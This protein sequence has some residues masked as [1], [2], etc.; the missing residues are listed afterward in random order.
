METDKD[1]RKLAELIANCA[2]TEAIFGMRNVSGIAM[3]AL[4]DGVLGP[5]NGPKTPSLW[6][7]YNYIFIWRRAV[8]KKVGRIAGA[9]MAAMIVVGLSPVTAKA[10]NP[11]VQTI[12]TT[13]P[14]P[15]VYGDTLYVYTGH[16]EDGASYYDMRDWHCYS[17]KDM[18]NWQDHGVVCSLNTFSWAKSDAWAGQVIERNGKFYYYV[19]VIAKQGGNSIGVAVS[20]S[21]TGPFKDAIGRPLCQGAS[22]ID[23]TV[24]VDPDG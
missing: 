17:T 22:F 8:M 4:G 16:D 24:Y 18:V 20:D 9:L 2:K 23:P 6:T 10:D 15:M 3:M 7:I 21:P 14:A 11:I 5:K 12:Y 19:P 1:N 13:D